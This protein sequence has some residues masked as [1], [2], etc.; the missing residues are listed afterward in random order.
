MEWISLKRTVNGMGVSF[1]LLNWFVEMLPQSDCT[2][3]NQSQQGLP[4][5]EMRVTLPFSIMLENLNLQK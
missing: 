1:E 5:Q 2:G 4:E 3:G